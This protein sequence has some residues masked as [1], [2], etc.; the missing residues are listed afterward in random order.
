MEML[1]FK[2]YLQPDLIFNGILGLI[3][4]CKAFFFLRVQTSTNKMFENQ[5]KYIYYAALFSQIF[6]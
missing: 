3:T 6:L 5:L 1:P 2:S 4:I